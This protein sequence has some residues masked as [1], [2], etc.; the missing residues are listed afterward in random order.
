MPD[1]LVIQTLSS[2]MAASAPLVFAAIGE[3]LTEKSGVVNLSLDGSILLSAMAGFAVALVSGSLLLGIGAAMLVGALVA[4][5]V[6][7]GSLALKQDPVAI[8]FVLTLL[9]A[10]LSSFLGK[11]YVRVPGPSVPHMPI[12]GLVDIPIIGPIL[13]NHNALV[14]LSYLVII[15]SWLW[16]FKTQPGLRLRS[17]GE[18]PAAAF[19]RGINVTRTRY[20]YTILGGALVGL[21]GATFS[22][23]V[24][25]GWSHNHTSGEGWI[26]LAIVIFGG[27]N[28]WRVALGAYLF[29]LL[30]SL[31]SILQPVYP[32]VPTQV[33]QAAP[34][35]LMIVALVLVS[36]DFTE[37]LA[38]YLPT[39]L[40][41]RV[42]GLL[43]GTP[44]AALSKPFEPE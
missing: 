9:G 18:R 11:P 16:I 37:R 1:S 40:R 14:Y 28:P 15:V 38:F 22:L 10:D 26:A 39:P 12:P 44:P 23:S 6:A 32:N 43:R 4:F 34:F 31:G 41:H 29:G 30:K 35:A 3:T 2:V 7:Y 42:T 33:F 19:A 17:V 25:L 27:W 13:F 24:R 21:A 20:L 36:G 5:I 8:G